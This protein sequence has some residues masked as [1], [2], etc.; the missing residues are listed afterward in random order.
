[1]ER[2]ESYSVTADATSLDPSAL[3]GGIGQVTFTGDATIGETRV[4][5]DPMHGEVTVE[6]KSVTDN[7][8]ALHSA[9]GDSSF[10]VMNA[11]RVVQPFTGT[12]QQFFDSLNVGVFQVHPSVAGQQVIAPGAEGNLWDYVRDFLS[13]HTLQM[14]LLGDEFVVEPPRTRQAVSRYLTDLTSS[15]SSDNAAQTV[16]INYFNHRWA[17]D[18]EVYPLPSDRSPAPF[19]VGAN[20]FSVQQIQLEG[21]LLTVNQP[22]CIEFV[23]DQSYEGTNGVYS[24]VSA[25]DSLPVTPAEWL[26]NGGRL[27]VRQTDNPSVIEVALFG[28]N[29]PEKAPFRIAMSSGNFYNS[30]HVTGTGYVSNQKS[31]TLYTGADLSVTGESLGVEVSNPHISTLEQALTAGQYTSRAYSAHRFQM[32]GGAKTLLASDDMTAAPGAMLGDSYRIDGTSASF[33]GISFDATIDI[34]AG[35]LNNR[36]PA[37]QTIGEWNALHPDITFGGFNIENAKTQFTA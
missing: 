18:V 28:A 10:I 22:E 29:I 26:D 6:V 30:L 4:I 13:A 25:A 31:I 27:E 3:T 12:I 19:V 37:G 34:T 35:T 15:V 8:Y 2:L 20:E 5:S 32:S 23:F 36:T 33:D 17:T 24:V 9:T 7:P 11:Y 16:K 14:Y 21:G 1:M